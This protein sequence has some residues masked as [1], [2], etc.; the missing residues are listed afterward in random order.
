MNPRSTGY[1]PA[2]ITTSLLSDMVG[3][4]GFEPTPTGYKPATLTPELLP[5]VRKLG[6]HHSYYLSSFNLIVPLQK[7]ILFPWKMTVVF[8]SAINK[9]CT[10]DLAEYTRAS[11]NPIA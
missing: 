6:H 2:E 9:H 8:P 1:E 3:K 5:N 10:I 4:V 11:F 7:I